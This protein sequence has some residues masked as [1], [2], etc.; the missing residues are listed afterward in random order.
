MI[1]SDS[2]LILSRQL[3]GGDSLSRRGL[4]VEV[5]N[6]QPELDYLT[7]TIVTWVSTTWTLCTSIFTWLQHTWVLST[8]SIVTWVLCTNYYLSI[9]YL[10]LYART[11]TNG[12]SIT[13]N[14][15]YFYN[16]WLRLVTSCN[17]ILKQRIASSWVT[18]RDNTINLHRTDNCWKFNQEQTISSNKL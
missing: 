8:S 10:S 4:E 2:L 3:L 5:Y 7:I 16:T 9:T 11:T 1:T 14:V 12:S 13:N 15:I 18:S 6:Q 17:D